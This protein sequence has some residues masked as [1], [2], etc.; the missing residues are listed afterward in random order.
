MM[1]KPFDE[2]FLNFIEKNKLSNEDIMSLILSFSR[3]NNQDYYERRKQK[4]M[5]RI[6]ALDNRKRMLLS[7]LDVSMKMLDNIKKPIQR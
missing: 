4:R 7:D 1:K 6:A 2:G 3:K 5:E